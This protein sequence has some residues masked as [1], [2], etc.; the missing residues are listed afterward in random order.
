MFRPKYIR[1]RM[2]QQPFV[3]ARFVTS[4]GQAYDVYHPDLVL[5]GRRDVHIGIPRTEG[6]VLY[7]DVVR[8]AIMHISVIEDLP[9]CSKSRP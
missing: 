3:P 7:E 1:D 9:R 4:L 6:E 8:L 5:V 2:R